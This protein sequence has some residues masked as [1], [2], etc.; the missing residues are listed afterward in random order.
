LARRSLE[1]HD[2]IADLDDMIE[3]IVK[4]LAPELLEQTAIGLNSA[5]Q[6]LLTAGDNPERL[7][8]EASFAA[9]CG[10]S[11]APASSGAFPV[12]VETRVSPVSRERRRRGRVLAIQH[13]LETL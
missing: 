2:E 10:M 8:S 7:K 13:K 4:D 12:F 3:A 1:R 9:L 11:P 5:A 6:L